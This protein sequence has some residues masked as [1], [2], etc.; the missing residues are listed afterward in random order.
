[1][2]TTDAHTPTRLS[3]VANDRH[4][5]GQPRPLVIRFFPRPIKRRLAAYRPDLCPAR[6]TNTP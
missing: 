4:A 2:S 1:M 5:A 6:R 3:G